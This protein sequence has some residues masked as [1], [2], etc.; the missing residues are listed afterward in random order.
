MIGRPASRLRIDPR[1]TEIGQIKPINKN[2]DNA[3]RIVLVD[4]ILQAL[5]KQ[6]ALGAIGPPR[7]ETI[8][9]DGCKA[10]GSCPFLAEG[11]T[12]L[13]LTAPVTATV[14]ST[15]ISQTSLWSSTAMNVI[16]ANIPHRRTLYGHDLVR[17]ENTVLGSPGG[18]GKSSL[19]IGIGVC[20]SITREL[21]GEKIYGA[22]LRTVLINAEDSTD[23]I[24]RRVLAFCMA[25]NVLEHELT[26]LHVAGAD[27][28]GVRGL[29][30]QKPQLVT[31]RDEADQ[32]RY[33]V[34]Q[35]LANREQGLLLKHQAVLF[36]SSSHSAPLEFELTRRNIPFVKFGGLKILDTAHVK[37]I[38]AILRF[39]ENSRDR[40]AGFR[41]LNLLP[42]VG[43]SSAKRVLDAIV[44]T[45]DP[46]GALC[47]LPAPPRAGADWGPFVE[48]VG[49]IRDARWPAEACPPLV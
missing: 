23:E 36:R 3:N 9:A 1:Q 38:L 24:R 11:K 46:A 4:P 43:P 31:V 18:A 33:V 32:A 15:P 26:R 7:C 47:S 35:V 29:S 39:V 5:R 48:T 25:H 17:G 20:I 44:E 42:G 27:H 13:H 10:C 2:V 14:T 12:P 21:L 34:E 41:L 40:V 49:N 8:H 6:R 28:P 30:S 16:F 37:D 19:A 45:A 22:E